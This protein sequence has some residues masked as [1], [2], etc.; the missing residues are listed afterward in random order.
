MTE[1]HLNELKPSSQFQM[2]S[3]PPV[4]AAVIFICY[5]CF[6]L[7]LPAKW[8]CPVAV[9]PLDHLMEVQGMCVARPWVKRAFW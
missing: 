9:W 3:W 7:D 6:L 1:L 2:Q 4:P 8:T 5:L